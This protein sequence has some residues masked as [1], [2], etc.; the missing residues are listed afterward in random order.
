MP[1]CWSSVRTHR[2]QMAGV[3]NYF[4]SASSSP[5]LLRGAPD[6]NTNTVS[7]FAPEAPQATASEGLAKGPYVAVRAGFEPATLRT[8]FAESTNE[9]PDPT[10]MMIMMMMMMTTTTTKCMGTYRSWHKYQRSY[11]HVF[12]SQVIF[13]TFS[14]FLIL[15]VNKKEKLERVCVDGFTPTH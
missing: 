3:R 15:V 10:M 8:K 9:P 6:H 11:M 12:H 2:H 1:Q 13:Y 5:L 4:Y 14:L 7:D